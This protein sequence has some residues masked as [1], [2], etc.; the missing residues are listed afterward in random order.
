MLG[1]GTARAL[2][3]ARVFARVVAP[4]S[5]DGDWVLDGF[6][7]ELYGDA[8][9]GTPPGA[10][11]AVSYYLSRGDAPTPVPFWSKQY[12]RRVPVATATPEAYAAALSSAFAE[13][14]AELARDLA[15]V[16]LPKP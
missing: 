13:I 15:A 14:T 7:D 10:E 4:G 3:R 8:R 11:L 6:V 5:A 16:E 12:R 1:E 2:D 9:S